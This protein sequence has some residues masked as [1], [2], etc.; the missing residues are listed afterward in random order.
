MIPSIHTPRQRQRRSYY[1]VRG[2]MEPKDVKA[3]ARLALDIVEADATY[4]IHSKDK[5][6]S[7]SRAMLRCSPDQ[8]K[9]QREN[10][11]TMNP[12]SPAIQKRKDT[13]AD[14]FILACAHAMSV[15]KLEF[16]NKIDDVELVRSLPLSAG[17]EMHMDSFIGFWNFLSPLSANAPCTII[18]DHVY[19]DFPDVFSASS[20]IPTSWDELPT[21][22]IDWQQGDILVLRNNHI[23]AGTSISLFDMP[24]LSVVVLFCLCVHITTQKT[25]V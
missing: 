10:G 19:Q 16:S 15:L 3:A 13:T 11:D 9:Q 8:Q 24:I 6:P 4:A 5:M 17:Q 12:V 25:S 14:A 18:K 23:H 1:V 2:M 21:V 7:V 22:A 20:G